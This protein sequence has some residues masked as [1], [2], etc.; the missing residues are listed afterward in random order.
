MDP[1]SRCK[2]AEPSSESDELGGA[3]MQAN[4]AQVLTLEVSVGATPAR[5]PIAAP[6]ILLQWHPHLQNNSSS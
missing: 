5:A 6:W 2:A 3:A 4:P 1:Q